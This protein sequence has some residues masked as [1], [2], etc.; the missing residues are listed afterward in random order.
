M[1]RQSINLGNTPGDGSGDGLR[2]ALSKCEANFVEL[3][4]VQAASAS[5]AELDDHVEDTNNPHNVTKGQVGLGNVDNTSDAS[6]PISTATQAALNLKLNANDPSVTNARTPTGGAGGVLSGSYPNPGFA[7]DM[8]TQSELDAVSAQLPAKADLVGGKVPSSQLPSVALT[9]YLGAVSSQSAMLLLTAEPGDFCFRTDQGIAYFCVAGNGSLIAHW[10]AVSTPASVGVTSVNG[11]VGVVVLGKGDIDLGNVDNTSDASK[12]ISTATQ[13]ALNGKAAVSHTHSITDLP[14]ASQAEAEAGSNSTKVMTPQ[15]VAQAIAFQ[16][17]PLV[18]GS[19]LVQGHTS[20]GSDALPARIDQGTNGAG[21]FHPGDTFRIIQADISFDFYFEV[22]D[23]G[24]PG[25]PAAVAVD[26]AGLSDVESQFAAF[27]NTVGINGFPGTIQ[28]SGGENFCRFET[29]G[30]GSSVTLAVEFWPASGGGDR[31]FT[32][33]FNAS[34]QGADEVAPSG[35]INEVTII[36]QSGTKTIK[37]VAIYCAGPGVGVGIELALKVGSSYFPLCTNLA[38]HQSGVISSIGSFYN[39]WL[40]GR[41]SA[42]LVARMTDTPP[43]G[44]S[45]RLVAVVEQI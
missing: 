23:G 39:E 34:A 30:A 3:Y 27:I 14:V 9:D 24:S 33:A 5:Q 12:P 35:A 28:Y 44:G 29:E 43:V 21:L 19:G 37:P 45:Q 26:I 11:H 7:V 18:R 31:P 2:T 17:P 4:E 13:T 8:A 10:Q 6:K 38:P 16:S 41:A 42:A 25:N 22:V 36:P 15:R 20:A 32:T 1:P 40:A